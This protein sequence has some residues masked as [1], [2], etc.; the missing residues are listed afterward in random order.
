MSGLVSSNSD[1]WYIPMADPM[2]FFCLLVSIMSCTEL[3][4]TL[5]TIWTE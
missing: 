4:N 1:S 2:W 3:F 5:F